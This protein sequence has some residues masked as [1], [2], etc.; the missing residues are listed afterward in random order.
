MSEYTTAYLKEI[1]SLLAK[2]AGIREESKRRR[3]RT[4]ENEKR[5]QQRIEEITSYAENLPNILA[6]MECAG[7]EHN[8]LYVDDDDLW[9][10]TEELRGII[11]AE[12]AIVQREFTASGF[13]LE[14][15]QDGDVLISFRAAPQG[16]GCNVGS[17]VLS[18]NCFAA[19]ARANP[20]TRTVVDTQR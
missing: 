11:A 16:C 9:Y 13:V 10:L 3:G 7:E 20:Q 6:D 17:Q 15:L 12:T 2:V 5:I 8:S 1:N 18:R 19:L 4:E 14:P